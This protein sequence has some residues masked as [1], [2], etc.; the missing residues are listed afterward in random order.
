MSEVTKDKTVEDLLRETK[1]AVAPA[2]YV[3]VR[4]THRDWARLLEDS[5]LSPSPESCFMIL[6]DPKEVTL[7]LEDDDWLRMRHVVRDAKVEANFRLV[8]LDVDLPW[9]VVG[10][11]ARVAAILAEA[12]IPLGALSSFSHDHVLLKQHDLA[13]ALRA[14]GE[15][16]GELC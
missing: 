7:L 10:Y 1:V 3:L 2:T 15:H 6:R 9:H 14:L 4:L 11:F 12:G 5:E 8:T 16:V 13:K